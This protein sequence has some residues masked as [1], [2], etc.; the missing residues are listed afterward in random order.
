[1]YCGMMGVGG[2]LTR[3]NGSCGSVHSQMRAGGRVWGQKHKT[4]S[5]LGLWC[6]IGGCWWM[7]VGLLGRGSSGRGAM[8]SQMWVWKTNNLKPSTSSF[9]LYQCIKKCGGG[10]LWGQWSPYSGDL[11][12]GD[13]GMSGFG[14]RRWPYLPG[15]LQVLLHLCLYFSPFPPSSPCSWDP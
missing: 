9:G 13:L 7:L 8:H 10:V 3:S 6:W 5:V 14:G 15:S 2:L 12:G 4:G 1:M 11:R